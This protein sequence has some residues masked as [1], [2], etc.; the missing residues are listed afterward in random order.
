MIIDGLQQKL[1]TH[2]QQALWRQIH[3]TQRLQPS[4]ITLNGESVWDFCSSDYLGLSNHP[5]IKQTLM[6]IIANK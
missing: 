6:D 1:A 5:A 4:Q 3:C 2:Q